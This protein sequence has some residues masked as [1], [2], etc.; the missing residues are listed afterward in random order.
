VALLI[1]LI[2]VINS[3]LVCDFVVSFDACFEAP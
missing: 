2:E 1:H 3:G